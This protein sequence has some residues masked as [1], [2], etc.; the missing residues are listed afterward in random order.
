[1]TDTSIFSYSQNIPPKLEPEVYMECD[2][3][4]TYLE[5]KR[6]LVPEYVQPIDGG[7][8]QINDSRFYKP[9]PNEAGLDG[10]TLSG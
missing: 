7:T 1:L 2:D 10:S 5:E 8:L 6:R 4:L 3:I 9:T